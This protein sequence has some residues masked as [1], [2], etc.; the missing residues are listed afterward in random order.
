MRIL[1]AID[2]SQCSQAAMQ[3]LK[4][5]FRA[6]DAEVH[7]LHAIDWPH[8]F[9]DSFSFAAGPEFAGEFQLFTDRERRKAHELADAAA[10]SF[11]K[12]GFRAASVVMEC[13]PKKAILDYAARWNPDLIVV[14]SHGRRGIDRIVL[15]S[16]SEAVARHAHCSVQIM[17]SAA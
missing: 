5:Q 2:G 10:V 3:A 4:N 12:A 15:G 9:P 7:V 8:L 17:R 14:G 13:D 1:L 11:R 6:E 16:V